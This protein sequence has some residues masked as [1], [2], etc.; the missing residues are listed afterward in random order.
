MSQAPF[1]RV[2]P[3][4]TIRPFQRLCH[5]ALWSAICAGAATVVVA[6]AALVF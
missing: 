4:R 1:N 3:L 5:G 2:T 6:V